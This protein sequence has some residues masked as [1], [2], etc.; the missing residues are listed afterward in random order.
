VS[1]EA[2]LAVEIG[3]LD[4]DVELR[5]PNGTIMA[6]VGPNGAGKTT[7]LRTLAGLI[8]PDRGRVL[9]GDRV[10]E[11]TTTDAW[12]PTER[13][14]VGMV[15][16]DHQ[17]FRDLSVRENVA[18]GLRARGVSRSEARRTADEWLARVG[19]EGPGDRRPRE[20]SGGQS[21]RVALARALA[22]SPALVL[23]DEPLSALDVE[24]RSTLRSEL[25]D[26]LRAR[27]CPVVLVTHD[28]DDARVVAD[29]VVVLEAGRI[30]QQGSIDSLAADPRSHY[31]VE[32]TRA[33]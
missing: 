4:L 11:D 19:L 8:A 1:L 15:F 25:R 32:L 29:T 18:F 14:G 17:L 26:H 7:L 30:T 28:I 13:R 10:L 6:I 9:L 21:Q 20:L 27:G 2:Q 22:I 24:T 3:P 5:V 33:R 16:Q 31:V 12:V 23:L